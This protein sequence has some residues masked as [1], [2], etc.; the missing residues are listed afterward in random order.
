MRIKLPI[1][2]L[3]S[4]QLWVNYS[5]SALI[6]SGTERE[7]GKKNDKGVESM[8]KERVTWRRTEQKRRR[9]TAS[10]SYATQEWMER[11]PAR[12][13]FHWLLTKQIVRRDGD[14]T[15]WNSVTLLE[16]MHS[17]LVNLW[18][19]AKNEMPASEWY[20]RSPFTSVLLPV[21]PCLL[22]LSL[23]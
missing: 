1:K 5:P 21:T 7:R 10:A 9:K 15:S 19:W 4:A 8:T 22:F 17:L 18:F 3:Q 13:S 11:G 14:A 6:R 12:C 20:N 2:E 23:H 16:Q